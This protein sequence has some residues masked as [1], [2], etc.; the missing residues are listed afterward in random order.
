MDATG[1]AV[2]EPRPLW[3]SSPICGGGQAP[4]SSGDR[5]VDAKLLRLEILPAFG[6]RQLTDIGSADV[7]AWY[8]SMRAT[9]TQQANAYGL[10]KSILKD[11]VEDGLVSRIQAGSRLAVRSVGPVRSR[12]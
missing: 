10:L 5:G 9:P 2:P 3:R 1:Q 6:D 4:A 12:Y 7:T 11:A 8:A